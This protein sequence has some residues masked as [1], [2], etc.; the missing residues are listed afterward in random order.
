MGTALAKLMAGQSDERTVR[1]AFARAD[2]NRNGT[3]DEKETREVLGAALD[4]LARQ[5]APETPLPS[6]R[7]AGLTLG[8]WRAAG[9][10]LRREVE[11]ELAAALFAVLDADG[12]RSVS[13]EEWRAFDWQRLLP[14]L[15]AHIRRQLQQRQPSAPAATAPAASAS[16]AVASPPAGPAEVS[17]EGRGLEALPAGAVGEGTRRLRLGGN[18]LARLPPLPPGLLELHAQNNRLAELP[19]E[20]PRALTRLRLD[21]NCLER[22]PEGLEELEE[23]GLLWL[24]GNPALP[25][26]WQANVPAA[27]DQLDRAAVAA[28]LAARAA[29]AAREDGSDS[30]SSGLSDEAE[31]KEAEA[32]VLDAHSQSMGLLGLMLNDEHR[33]SLTPK[34]VRK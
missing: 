17:L 25:P 10:A 26:A 23:L 24:A 20:L 14:L 19:A 28:F 1:E 6:A 18:R 11:G 30:D 4:C 32:A 33:Q 31:R 15:E 34:I 9:P 2:K 3:L 8:E 5:A 22:P 29:E 27:E 21:G 7:G 13:L 16:G 12:S